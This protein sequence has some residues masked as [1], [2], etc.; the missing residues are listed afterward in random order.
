MGVKLGLLN[1]LPNIIRM[2]KSRGCDEKG[3]QNASGRSRMRINGCG[4]KV[5]RKQTIRKINVG[6]KILGMFIN[7]RGIG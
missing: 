1:S 4:G 3:M 2:I 6:L 5:R 7:L